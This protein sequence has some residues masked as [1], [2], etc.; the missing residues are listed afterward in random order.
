MNALAVFGA[1]PLT[2][3]VVLFETASA[4]AANPVTA[5]FNLPE[6]SLRS[7]ELVLTV[8]GY[9]KGVGGSVWFELDGVGG[10]VSS[11]L[12]PSFAD[13]WLEPGQTRE[14]RLNLGRRF[15]MEHSTRAN[16]VV[17]TDAAHYPLLPR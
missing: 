7:A 16:Y 2:Q 8:A 12:A 14:L 5:T 1:K 13:G 11:G 6:R 15:K 10:L 3:E 4:L 9:A 17:V